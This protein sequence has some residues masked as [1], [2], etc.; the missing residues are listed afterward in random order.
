MVA[1]WSLHETDR[2]TDTKL[3]FSKAR[4]TGSSSQ[5]VSFRDSEIFLPTFGNE[6]G[7]A[8]VTA[9]LTSRQ[10]MASSCIMP[11][12]RLGLFA[13]LYLSLWGHGGSVSMGSEKE[14]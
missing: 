8:R 13:S 6:N 4:N 7:Q 12:Q 14:E 5:V 10:N 2:K 1:N 9:F 3:N 11:G